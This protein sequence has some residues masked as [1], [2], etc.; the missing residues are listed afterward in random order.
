M[1]SH[2]ASLTNHQAAV[3]NKNASFVYSDK[4]TDPLFELLDV[5]LG[6]R[7]LDLGCG[8]GELTARLGTLV[9]PEGYVLGADSSTDM[10]NK[11]K[12]LTAT[13][14][15][16]SYLPAIDIQLPFGDQDQHEVASLKGSF[17]LVFSNA[18][19]H[20]CKTDPAGVL[21]NVEWLLKPGG[22]F[23][24]EMGGQYNMI[25]VR[26]AL[27]A[28]LDRRG[29]DPKPLDPWFF[30]SVREYSIVVATTGLKVDTLGLHFRPTPLPESGLHGWLTT[31]AKR[32]FLSALDEDTAEQVMEE[33]V[34]ECSIDCRTGD[35]WD[36]LYSR[37]RGVLIKA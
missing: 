29:I 10:L 18:T 30:P 1:P 20:W 14:G 6:N 28:A 23:V 35:Q 3:Y 2:Q 8:S 12:S 19:L 15:S 22:K 21:K 13:Q 34:Q 26:G 32:S 36:V 33:V 7:I 16:I 9:G 17:D 11:A 31:F 4:F 24:F 25:G 27:H 5:Q 37:L